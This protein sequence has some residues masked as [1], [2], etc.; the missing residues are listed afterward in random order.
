ERR[1]LRARGARRVTDRRRAARVG[2]G[3]HVRGA[4][5]AF[6]GAPERGAVRAVLS[7]RVQRRARASRARALGRGDP[8]LEEPVGISRSATALPGCS[9]RWGAWG[10]M[11]GP[12]MF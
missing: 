9:E 3:R 10:A 6:R 1:L 5:L 12:P 4:A 2:G 7:L 8:G 11:S